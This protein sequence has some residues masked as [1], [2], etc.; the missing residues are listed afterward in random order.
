[1]AKSSTLKA[2]KVTLST[3]KVVI[4]R[5][6]QIDDTEQAAAIVA[7]R[8]DGDMNLLQI[9]MQKE[10]LKRVLISIDDKKLSANEKEDLKS[11]LNM[12]EYGQLMKV[13]GEMSGGADAGKK[14]KME[15]VSQDS[16]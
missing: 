8:A 3:G 12:T 5:E 2:A 9:F 16:E 6:M 11:V 13:I 7:P 4:L 14:P 15:I 1:M 10:I